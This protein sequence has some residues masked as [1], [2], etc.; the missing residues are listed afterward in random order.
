MLLIYLFSEIE[1]TIFINCTVFLLH[2]V[3][4]GFSKGLHRLLARNQGA[5]LQLLKIHFSTAYLLLWVL[6]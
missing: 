2:T 6:A 4:V 3:E 1:C 5:P